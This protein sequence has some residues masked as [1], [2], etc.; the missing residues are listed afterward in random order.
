MMRLIE[1][2]RAPP[3]LNEKLAKAESLR[4]KIDSFDDEDIPHLFRF[5]S[6]QQLRELME[7]L[8]FPEWMKS[9]EGCIFHRE[10]LLLC[11]LYRLRRPTA[12]TCP[13][14]R[15]LFG[16]R[17]ERV[18]SLF[19]LFVNFMTQNWGYL[20][21]DNMQYWLPH[22]E[23]CAQAIRDKLHR[24]GCPFPSPTEPAGFNVFGFIDNTMN[25]TCRPG[26]V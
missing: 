14:F 8:R 10:E 22:L 9:E 6:K 7:G 23:T 5:E 12:M 2:V 13:T 1:I 21:L 26:D 11:S 18:S 20:L 3:E 25:A 16:F 15:Y 24:L 19:R 17:N 4:R